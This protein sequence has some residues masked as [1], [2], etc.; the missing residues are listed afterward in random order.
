MRQPEHLMD[1][2]ILHELCHIIEKNHGKG[3]WALLEKVSGDAKGLRKDL[4]GSNAKIY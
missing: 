4:R 1:Y 3:F 2:I